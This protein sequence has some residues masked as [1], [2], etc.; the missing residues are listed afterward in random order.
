M[1]G[2]Q[3][4]DPAS[5]GGYQLLGRLG[6]GGMGQVFLGVSPSGRR[7]AVKLIHPVHAGTEHFRERF[8]REIEAARRVGGFHTAPVV[9]ADPHADPPWM[10]TAYIDG[11]S[12]EEAVRRY[13]PMPPDRVRALG[14]GLAEGLA[15]IHAHG[16]IHRDLK[17]GNVIMAEDGPRIIDFGIARSVDSTGLTSTGAVVGTFAYMSP[18][19]IRGDM[20]TPAMDVFSLGC[21]LAYAATGRPPFGSDTAAAVMFRI[22]GHPPDL[23]GVSDLGVRNLIE[24][25][26]AK[27]PED[28]L[29]VP[30]LLAAVTNRAPMPAVTPLAVPAADGHNTQTHPPLGMVPAGLAPGRD[31][32]AASLTVPPGTAPPGA[33]PPATAL[34]GAVPPGSAPPGPM[35]LPAVAPG[36]PGHARPGGGRPRRRR[37]A[38]IA[39]IVGVIALAAGIPAWVTTGSPRTTAGHGPTQGPIV[40]HP[41]T[42]L[43]PTH[44]AT[45]P[46]TTHPATTPATS[47]PATTPATSHPATAPGPSDTI[48]AQNLTLRAPGNYG[49]FGLAFSSDGRH[50]A[51]GAGGASSSTYVWD[52]TTGQLTTL[53]A[54]PGSEF[55]TAVAISPNAKQV[56][57]V[58][59]NDAAYLWNLSTGQLTATLTSPKQGGDPYAVAF[60]PDSTM[61]AT[62]EADNQ[63]DLWDIATG[64]LTRV[65]KDASAISGLA[66]SPNGTLLA[67]AGRPTFLWDVATGQRYATLYDPGGKAVQA[68]AFSPDG[69]LV[70]AADD[71]GSAYLWNVATRTVVATLTP[72]GTNSNDY[73]TSIAFSPDGTLVATA[74]SNGHAYLW[75]VATHA[76]AGT[77]TDPGRPHVV[78]VAFSPNGGVLA[79]SDDNGNVYIRVTSQLVS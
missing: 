12:L 29:T 22:V 39:V 20:A 37:A 61:L 5:V 35:P 55:T 77:F 21:V 56:A 16:L 3:R 69:K 50:V 75:S 78:G 66:F 47:H 13:G 7:V 17:P 74:D 14:A 6:S 73:L 79:I 9:D 63:T 46:A 58:T 23:A 62:G 51:A 26:L 27:S 67:A 36:Q 59:L 33:F 40:S 65:L 41:A 54:G 72:P 49:L 19:Q 18:E 34:P 25:C 48:P 24:G 11:P 1:E 64:A 53:N 43:G 31:S 44:P 70:A 15:A 32:L 52:I 10:V 42:T 28:R 2:L 4:G 38:L 60:S 57:A 71:N 76:L 8:A 68:V 30:A 45:T